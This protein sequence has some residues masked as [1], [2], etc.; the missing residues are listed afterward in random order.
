MRDPRVQCGYMKD[1]A[2]AL[3][4]LGAQGAA[5]R[6]A[7]EA[8]FRELEA[9]PRAAWLPVSMNVR[10]VEAVCRAFG[11]PA[12]LDFLAARVSEQFGNPLFRSF[13][14]GG[15]RLFGLNPGALLRL[16]PR[17]LA[18]VFRDCGEWTAVRTSETSMELRGAA[19]PSELA[20][21][22]HWVESIGAGAIAMLALC[23]TSGDVRLAEHDAR[24]GRAVIEVRWRAQKAA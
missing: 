16:I 1:V 10:W 20:A 15:I 18:I 4:R 7:D 5:V 24:L 6:A 3:S 9:S 21:H 17:G 12:A 8:L 11:W 22:P 23:R 2:E 14:E 13:V 19:L